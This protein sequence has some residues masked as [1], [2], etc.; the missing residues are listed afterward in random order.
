MNSVSKVE[1]A[2]KTF[3]NGGVILVYDS[4][5]REGEVDM[6]I[7]GTYV[8]PEMVRRLRLEAGGLL[9]VAID[10]KL[11]D[12]LG[13]PYYHQ[14]VEAA[15][16][17]YPA[18]ERL[19]RKKM[20]YGDAPAFSITIN[21]KSVYTG[22]SDHERALTIRRF[23]TLCS[24]YRN[25]PEA[26]REAVAAEFSTPGHVHLLI[27][28]KS[29]FSGRR[30]HTEY[31]VALAKLAGRIPVVALAEMLDDDEPR[32]LPIEKAERIA[33]ERGYQLLYGSEIEEFWKSVARGEVDEDSYSSF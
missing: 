7:L 11:A 23:A 10:N 19:L 8:T 24:E 9:C 33:R 26:L 1:N 30:G 27:S 31:A 3:A 21:H 4:S 18:L 17:S 15:A 6:M 32:A 28:S 2:L 16:S 5:G 29:L 14:L 22:I 25:N 12:N 20:P 13:I